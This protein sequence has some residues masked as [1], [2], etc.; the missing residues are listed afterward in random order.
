MNLLLIPQIA[1]LVDT[2]RRW[3]MAF[4]LFIAAAA[5]VPLRL[6]RPLA[7]LSLLLQAMLSMG[8]VRGFLVG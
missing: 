1:P 7:F 6:A 4:P 3:M 5:H 2:P 8:F